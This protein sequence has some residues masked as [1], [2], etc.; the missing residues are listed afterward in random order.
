MAQVSESDLRE[1]IDWI[2]QSAERIRGFQRS[3][4]TAGAELSVNWQ[5]ESHEAFKRIHLQWHERFDVILASLQR[6]AE[7]IRASNQNYAEFNANAV[8]E[9]SKIESLI[10]AAPPSALR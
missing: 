8:Q 9:I 3:L 10:N 2:S 1:A 5:G 6:L 7:N 4:D